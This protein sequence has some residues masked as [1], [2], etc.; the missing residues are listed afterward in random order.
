[1]TDDFINSNTHFED[2]VSDQ[3]EGTY[4]IEPL[5]TLGSTRGPL[6][7][8][9]SNTRDLRRTPGKK[10]GTMCHNYNK[11]LNYNV[12][13]GLAT[14]GLPEHKCDFCSAYLFKDEIAHVKIDGQLYQT[15]S[16]CCKRGTL[17]IPLQPELP[18]TLRKYFIG[19]KYNKFR[20]EEIY[21]INNALS[22]S[23]FK[24]DEI[25]TTPTGSVFCNIRGEINHYIMRPLEQV[26]DPAFLQIWFLDSNTQAEAAVENQQK[27]REQ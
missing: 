10:E 17:N 2:E 25:G 15:S 11:H 26:E 16:I 20:N 24:A 1:M 18:N 13:F 5:D 6:S 12:L 19:K 23:S 3:N 7:N 21:N 9:A 14:L 22:L 4:I 8:S 27:L